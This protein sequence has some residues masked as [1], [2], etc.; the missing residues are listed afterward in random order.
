M[1]NINY[2]NHNGKR[3][4]NMDTDGGAWIQNISVE[5]TEARGVQPAP[6]IATMGF[7]LLHQPTGMS[8]ADFNN[9][10]KVRSVY[11]PMCETAVQCAT[12]ASA[13]KCFHHAIRCPAKGHKGYAGMAHCDY[14][15]LNAFNLLSSVS[16]SGIDTAG[17]KGRICVYNIWRNINPDSPILN[18]H[19]AMC[20]GS[21]VIAP[22]DFV[23][24]DHHEAGN[25]AETF[26]MAPQNARH[27]R[28]YYFNYMSADEALLFT[29]FDSN[30][31][32]KCRYTPHSSITLNNEFLNFERESIEVRM[33][34]FFRQDENT[35]PDL[36]IPEALRVPGA[37]DKIRQDMSHL[38]TWDEQGK[39]FV[40][41]HA[42]AG[43]LR[44]IVKGSCVHLRKEGRRGEFK[45]LTDA[46]I[47]QVIDGALADR[48]I[49]DQIQ[50]ALGITVPS[51]MSPVMA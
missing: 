31:R 51:S 35:L 48:F 38:A 26:H 7:E 27:H 39:N 46:Q 24:Y 15:C 43:N 47:D 12:G 17:F 20:D 9:E 21:S 6:S 32:A 34:A 10:D 42:V 25:I 30:P 5:V 36:T 29:Q 40:R 8:P 18:H 22:D 16:P 19:L 44:E 50:S 13:V 1:V 37:V 3:Q 14:S 41:D 45:D 23:I 33:V 11:Y 2:R 49:A 4:S 28:W